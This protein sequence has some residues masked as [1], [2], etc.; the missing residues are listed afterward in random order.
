[1]E[2]YSHGPFEVSGYRISVDDPIGAHDLI[3]D[4]W[5]TWFSENIGDRVI[6]KAYPSLYAVYYNYRDPLDPEKK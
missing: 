5:K 1:M 6:E 3:M 2:K 4:T